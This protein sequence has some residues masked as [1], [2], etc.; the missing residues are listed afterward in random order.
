MKKIILL[1]LIGFSINSFGQNCMSGGCSNEIQPYPTYTVSIPNSNIWNVIYNDNGGVACFD[2]GNYF[3][4][5]VESGY[6]YDWTGCSS[7]TG[8]NLGQAFDAVLTLKDNSGNN[9]CYS[10]NS[11]I[12]SCPNVPYLSW[13][14]TYTGQVKLLV[15]DQYSMYC[16]STSG[17]CV[18][19]N[20][21]RF[22]WRRTG[23]PNSGNVPDA[24]IYSLSINPDSGLP[25]PLVGEDVDLEVEV[26]N[27]G[28]AD[29]TSALELDYFIDG[30]QIDNDFING[31]D[32]PF[33][34]SA[35]EFE[36]EK[37][38]VFSSAGTYQYC[39]TVQNHSEETN[40][41]NNSQCMTIVVGN[42]PCTPVSITTQPF[43][44]PIASGT[45]ISFAVIVNTNTATAPISY[46]WFLDGAPIVGATSNLY[47]TPN[48]T[49]SNN[50]DI[51]T[52]EITNCGGTIV[53]NQCIINVNSACVDVA[54]ATQPTNQSAQI[55]GSATFSFTKTAAST[56][57][58]VYQWRKGNVNISN[59]NGGNNESLVLS[60]VQ[61][62]DNGTQYRCYVTNCSSGNVLTNQA[63]LTVTNNCVAVGISQDLTNQPGNIGGNVTFTIIVSGTG[64][65][66]YTWRKNG[67]IEN[68][69]NSSSSTSSFSMNNL[70]SSNDGDL[71]SCRVKNCN[72]TNDV[73]S[74]TAIL[75]VNSGSVSPSEIIVKN[76]YAGN[77]SNSPEKILWEGFDNNQSTNIKICADGS[78]TTE[79]TF[80]NNNTFINTNDIR[81]R[82]LS[83]PNS[84]NVDQKGYFSTPTINNI[85]GNVLKLKYNH[86]EYVSL[87]NG[88]TFNYDEIE[89][90]DIT[91]P[92][93]P[94]F[95]IP[96]NI[97]RAPVL[98][99]H[100]LNSD[101]SVFDDMANEL[102]SS[103]NYFPSLINQV[104]Y[105]WTN[106]DF[107]GV[108]RMVIPKAIDKILKK[109]KNYNYSAGKVDV[110]GHSMGGVLAR[111]YLQHS[112]PG[113]KYDIHKLI[114]LN[115]P[116]YGSQIANYITENPFLT[117]INSWNSGYGWGTSGT[118]NALFDLSVDS[119]EMYRINYQNLN[120]NIVPSHSVTTIILPNTISYSASSSL[121]NLLTGFGYTR[122]TFLNNLY[123]EDNDLMVAETSQKGGISTN[124]ITHLSN[125][126][127]SCTKKQAVIDR[128]EVLLEGTPTGS[129]SLFSSSG[130]TSNTLAYTSFKTE[131]ENNIDITEGSLTINSPNSN[132][133][134]NAG[135]DITV[136]ATTINEISSMSFLGFH[137]RVI[138]SRIDTN[139]SQG[140]FN[141]TIPEDAFKPI[142]ILVFGYGDDGLVDFDTLTLR[143]NPKFSV[144]SL[145]FYGDTLYVPNNNVASAT[146]KAYRSN[147]FSHLISNE[148][149][150]NYY[151]ENPNLLGYHFG[152]LFKGKKIGRTKITAEYQGK[153]IEIP[154]VVY[155]GDTTI[156]EYPPKPEKMISAIEDE[157][158]LEENML[159]IFPNP[160]SGTFSI[161]FNTSEKEDYEI[162]IYNQIGA[163]VFTKNAES[164]HNNFSH[165]VSLKNE[166]NGIYYVIA[167]SKTNRKVGKL[168]I[169]KK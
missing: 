66:E 165:Q 22:A 139:I 83:D 162:M 145:T 82:V 122:T 62:G 151:I 93:F 55:G 102:V 26:Q 49:T 64:P 86:P 30:V 128:V 23:S 41:T 98:L 8:L 39:V 14:A 138:T 76:I 113:Y 89:I 59:A 40:Y 71:V 9:L 58:F 133:I 46:Q 25:N 158:V 52:C 45:A 38:Y 34:P 50:G 3:Y 4:L 68:V 144:D 6:T 61:A 154:V 141:Y 78:N 79:I 111:K 18:N 140:N 70:A 125:I 131:E 94:I 116:H 163:L 42:A 109:L 100:G 43:S 118:S 152:N 37:N 161:Q 142:K 53:S 129:N 96:V 103:G 114:T 10:E 72:G 147:G 21:T 99:I 168:S 159:N 1:I 127:H 137:D 36:D 80:I 33:A 169:T 134:F 48:Q 101:P 75:T 32:I 164:N 60:N 5:N 91:N 156:T 104:D 117:A 54:I 27:V 24:D 115:T 7:V 87:A 84:L 143:V 73:T 69:F 121:I 16:G 155:P 15:S 20:A 92:N 153:S 148:P 106:S 88:T 81:F 149:D 112:I 105:E 107:F 146:V 136:N 51:Y 11:G 97:Y 74:N 126:D 124:A 28:N 65:F 123:A 120:N 2:G 132:E 108:N 47:T 119:D 130:Y 19:G 17:T 77:T 90:Y 12:A 150:I 29:F 56:G 167:Q 57:P 67:V 110:V 135:E 157:L 35:I 95:N 31:S 63:T 44:Q 13:T 85:N 160:N 166:A